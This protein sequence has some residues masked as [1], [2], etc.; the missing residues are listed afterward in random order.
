MPIKAICTDIDGTLLDRNR[1]LSPRTRKAFAS[2]RSEFPVILAS[3]RMP[4][5]MIHLLKD[6]RRENNPLICYN[7]GFVLPAYS[8]RPLPIRS[9]W[10]PVEVCQ[11]IVHLSESTNIHLSLYSENSWYAPKMDAWTAKEERATKVKATLLE[12]SAVLSHWKQNQS[13][14][15]KVMCMGPAKE[16]QTLYEKLDERLSS[17]LHLYRSKDTYLE[18]APKPISKATGL[19]EV[20]SKLDI[21]M[22][23]VIAFGDNYNDVDLLSSVGLGVAVENAIGEVKAVAREITASNTADGVA[24][25]IEKYLL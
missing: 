8:S 2:L 18:I 10:I 19:R 12:N 4:S 15:H 3:S 23:E 11:Q 16:I 6:L 5:A 9:V 24:K 20:L 21:K 14:A 22:E 25:T 1:E 13:G 17:V 7:G